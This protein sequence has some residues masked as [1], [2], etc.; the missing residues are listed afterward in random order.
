MI[1]IP[2]QKL[3]YQELSIV[4]DGQN[5]VIAVRQMGPFLYLTLTA[6][7]EK[8]CDSHVCQ[9]G[10]PIPVWNTPRF[11]GRLFWQ[12]AN[13]TFQPPQYDELGERF[14][15]YYATADEWQALTA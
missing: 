13:G 14:T 2:L 6:D 1:Q 3:P 4:L 11:S 9:T 12:D 7:E 10:E 5:C 15:L 8:I